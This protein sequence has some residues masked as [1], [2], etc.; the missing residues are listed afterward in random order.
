[1]KLPVSLQTLG[2]KTALPLLGIRTQG[3]SNDNRES[4]LVIPAELD[5]RIS[6]KGMLTAL[7]SGMEFS[8][9][10]HAFRSIMTHQCAAQCHN[11][12]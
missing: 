5:D 3:M 9:V 7:I 12:T 4:R 10:M 6:A 2:L 1:L 11:L 8:F